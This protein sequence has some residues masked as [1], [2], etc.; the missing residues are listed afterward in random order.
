MNVVLPSMWLFLLG[1]VLTQYMCSKG[2]FT[3]MS[4]CLYRYAHAHARTLAH[5]HIRARRNTHAPTFAT[6]LFASVRVLLLLLFTMSL[7]CSDNHGMRSDCVYS[8]ITGSTN[9]LTVTLAITLRKFVSLLISIFYFQ[10]EFTLMHWFGTALVF[11]G[12][13]F[14]SIKPAAYA[15][16]VDGV[17]ALLLGDKKQL[18]V[19]VKNSKDV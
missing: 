4:K 8:D 13:Y 15:N 1:N 2:V 16:T 5:T 12:T 19:S 9:A 17:V 7:L 6:A 18:A 11:A 10:N 14:Y 3:L